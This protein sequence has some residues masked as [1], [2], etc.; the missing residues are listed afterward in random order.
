VLRLPADPTQLSVLRRRLEDFLTAHAVPAGDIFDLTVA[1][2][3]AAA[4]A[5][6]HPVEPV[7]PVITVEMSLDENAVL[8]TVRDTGSW[9][10]ATD[11]GFRGRGLALIGALSELS[12][13]RSA[14]GTAVT[15]RRPLGR[16]RD[17]S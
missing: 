7:E 13:A 5:I 15:L 9:R 2:S 8:A 17:R 6:E 14:T 3:E 1:I 10:P 4:N 12:V 11:A 16:S